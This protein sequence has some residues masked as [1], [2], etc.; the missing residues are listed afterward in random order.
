MDYISSQKVGFN[1]AP[2]TVMHVDINSCFATIE[3][4]A[5]PFLR[6][7]PVVVGAYTTNSGCI[8]AASREAKLLG[9]K[10]GMRVSEAK[11][12]CPTLTV[13]PPDPVKYRFIN[14]KLAALLG[15]YTPYMSVESIDE[16]VMDISNLKLQN[17]KF[18][19][20]GQVEREMCRIAGEIKVRIKK[21]IGEWITVS[22]G[23]APNRYLAK[24]GSG[25]HKPDGLDIITKDTIETILGRMT[26]SDLCGIKNGSI[27]RLSSVGIG[28]PMGFYTA[29]PKTLM[30]AFRSI[31]G[32]YWFFRLHGWEDGS[33]YTGFSAKKDEQKSFGHSFALRRFCKPTDRAFLQIVS[34]LII[35][36]GKRLR[37]AGCTARGVGIVCV[38]ADGGSWHETV[39]KDTS[40]FSDWDFWRCIQI[41]L[42][43]A[44]DMRVRLVAVTCWDLSKNLYQQTTLFN[45]EDKKERMTRAVDAVSNRWGIF[46]LVPARLLQLDQQVLDRIAFGKA[47]GGSQ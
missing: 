2:P 16:M 26:L 3:Q 7:K 21:E 33:R 8:L 9:I 15:G 34:Q 35:K 43:N 19:T 28:T 17:S 13:L 37:D 42:K 24:V 44:P 32:W 11:F 1:P 46:T 38:L 20:N 23:I 4:Q 41:M 22:I 10:T 29:S 6:G 45:E 31:L 39:K 12:Y 30:Q 5:N 25:L 47:G 40:L 18:K 14:K 27:R 36:M